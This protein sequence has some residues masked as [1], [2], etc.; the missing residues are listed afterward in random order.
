MYQLHFQFSPDLLPKNLVCI[1]SAHDLGVPRQQ[2]R[3]ITYSTCALDACNAA[4]AETRQ[5]NDRSVLLQKGTQWYYYLH[6]GWTHG[7]LFLIHLWNL[8]LAGGLIQ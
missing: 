4:G 3:C 7:L 6:A 1:M 5:E 8:P 2:G